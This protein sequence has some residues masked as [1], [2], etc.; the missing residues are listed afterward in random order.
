MLHNQQQNVSDNKK[1]LQQWLS[2][3]NENKTKQSLLTPWSVYMIYL[4]ISSLKFQLFTKTSPKTLF[5]TISRQWNNPWQLPVNS[6][7]PGQPPPPPTENLSSTSFQIPKPLYRSGCIP[8]TLT[9]LL[10]TGV[11]PL[12][13]QVQS[14]LSQK[15]L[16]V[17][18]EI[19]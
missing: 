1:A 7:G 16:M 17:A 6:W 19:F 15:H 5:R 9:F 12:H 18:W 13:L 4:S 10:L 14:I 11:Q 3:F 2:C 8:N